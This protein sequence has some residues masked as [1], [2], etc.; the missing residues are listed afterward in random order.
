LRPRVWALR[1][2]EVA[3]PV[4]PNNFSIGAVTF[5]K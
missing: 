5:D 4:T 3:K 2:V 1:V